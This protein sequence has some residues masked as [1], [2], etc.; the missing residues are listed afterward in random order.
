METSLRRVGQL[1][2]E[3]DKPYQARA[4]FDHYPTPVAFA[5]QA[6]AV[7]PQDF[8]PRYI[9]D[10][11]AGGGSWGEAARGLWPASKIHGVEIRRAPR[12]PD[13]TIWSHDNYLSAPRYWP[14]R[15]D[16]IMGNPPYG[17][18]ADDERDDR[19]AEKFVR[20]AMEDVRTG[21]YIMFLLLGSFR[22]S[23][24][25]AKG[26]WPEFPPTMEYDLVQR[27]SF[28][29]NN[30]TD[31]RSYCLFI[32]QKGAAFDLDPVTGFPIVRRSWI[33]WR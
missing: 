26:L 8:K 21:G 33:S 5:Q 10:P 1:I 32:W 22:E 27:V 19:T 25:R 4:A 30:R 11:G 13:Y 23:R 17:K 2:I 18:N 9:L 3:S 7:L 20:K 16:L 28:S 6:L 12:H 15:Y 31:A 24:I 29:G 14:W